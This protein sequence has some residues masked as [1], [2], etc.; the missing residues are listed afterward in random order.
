MY[1]IYV[2]KLKIII[3]LA[4]SMHVIGSEKNAIKL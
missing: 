4:M 3:I 1:N 2:N